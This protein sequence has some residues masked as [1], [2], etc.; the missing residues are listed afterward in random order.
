MLSTDE[1]ITIAHRAKIREPG[2][3]Q[4]GESPIVAK[5]VARVVTLTC[6][7][8]IETLPIWRLS[9]NH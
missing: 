7:E 9:R 5:T 3:R 4:S 2:K 8:P 6:T 1:R